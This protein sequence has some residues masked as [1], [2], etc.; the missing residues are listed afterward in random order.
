M[1]VAI[2]QGASGSLGFALARHILR[3]TG[4]KVYALTHRPSN[5][6]AD[7]SEKLLE[8]LSDR[9]RKG[10]GK[11]SL[12]VVGDVDLK[13]EEGLSKAA[14]MVKE[15]EGVDTV[16]LVACM[17]GILHPEKSLSAIDLSKSIDQF[18][19]NTLGHLLTY[20]H[21]V[22]LIPSKK[23]FESI[24]SGSDW[25]EYDGE[26]PAR[27]L[28]NPKNSLCWS[29]SARVGSISDNNR[30][31]WYSYRASKAATNQII[32]TLDHELVVNKNS[33]AIAVGYH[34]GTVITSFTKPVIGEH[35]TPDPDKGRF[36][37][38]QAIEKMTGVM[39]QVK[40]D[41]PKKWEGRCWDWKGERIEW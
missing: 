20:K 41:D 35:A 26:D 33:S 31:G 21:F 17:A 32:R 36:D 13:D 23:K 6:E 40:R 19:I 27:G 18:R 24:S 28:I 7:L 10:K 3:N 25:S 2:I 38:D 4:L 39:S 30:G 14:R 22:P 8:D 16:R 37:I 5:T 12:T 29:M 1:S 9:D 15:R 34:P 11:D